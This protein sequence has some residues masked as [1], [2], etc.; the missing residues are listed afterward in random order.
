MV[1][2]FATAGATP[3]A[4]PNFNGTLNLSSATTPQAKALQSAMQSAFPV[5]SADPTQSAASSSPVS[6]VNPNAAFNNTMGSQ[7]GMLQPKASTPLKSQ[8]Q[9]NVDGSSI[10]NTYHPAATPETSTQNS[11][12]TGGPAIPNAINQYQPTSGLFGQAVTGLANT[13]AVGSPV[14]QSAIQDTQ[15][16]AQGAF[17]TG[18]AQEQQAYQ[19]AQD[20]QKQ[21]S[22]LISQNATENANINNSPQQIDFKQG[23]GAALQALFTGQENAASQGLQSQATL[24]GIGQQGVGQGVT[25][26][27][28]AAGAANTAQGQSISGLGTA[29]GLVGPQQV[30]YTNQFLDPITGQPISNNPGTPFTGGVAQGNVLL[31]QQY[32]QNVSANNQAQII[33]GK[34]TDFL[35][36]NPNLNPSIF[37]DAN[38]LIQLMN[39]KVSNPQYQQLSNLLTEYVNTLAPILGVG[40]DT[41]NLKTQIAQGFINAHAN[42]QSIQTVLDGIEQLAQAK[43]NAQVGGSQGSSGAQRG[44]SQAGSLFSW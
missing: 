25:G 2:S 26:L 12:P 13:A 40:G 11:I 33:K 7:S 19:A 21:L 6:T 23:Q 5:Q 22:G 28:N 29:A 18:T 17:N 35:T 30:P 44:T 10:T 31:G 14:A 43:L 24:A 36:Q 1:F 34:I 39:G 20:Y 3:A 16:A 4:A 27:G 38:G 8:T 41:T 42:N 37:S 15:K 9:T 32:A